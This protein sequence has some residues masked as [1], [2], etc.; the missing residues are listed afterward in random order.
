[1]TLLQLYCNLFILEMQEKKGGKITLERVNIS[2]GGFHPGGVIRANERALCHHHQVF[3]WTNFYHTASHHTTPVSHENMMWQYFMLIRNSQQLQEP[4]R[5][6]QIPSGCTELL[7]WREKVE[8]GTGGCPTGAIFATPRDV[9]FSPSP[10][11]AHTHTHCLCLPCSASSTEYFIWCILLWVKEREE[12]EIRSSYGP[13]ATP[14]SQ[15][16]IM[17]AYSTHKSMD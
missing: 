12:E 2:V 1:M 13:S 5:V 11:H 17:R 6:N 15:R 4:S 7:Q 14:F 9:V 16:W 3:I 10:V 8:G